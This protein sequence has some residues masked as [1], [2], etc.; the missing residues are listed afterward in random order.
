MS[1][2]E[3][4]SLIPIY[5]TDLEKNQVILSNVLLM[6]SRRIYID[7]KEDSQP[8]YAIDEKADAKIEVEADNTYVFKT[9][10]KKKYALR[11]SYHKLISIGKQSQIT[12][13]IDDYPDHVK[14]LVASDFKPAIAEY[15]TKHKV[16]LYKEDFFLEDI[17]AYIEQPKY[18]LLS[19]KQMEQVKA[20]YGVTNYTILKTTRSDAVVKYLGLKKGDIYKVVRPS[21]V[22]G[23]CFAYRI[24]M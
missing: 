8:L 24:V 10:N 21:P 17:L 20:E 5:K 18:V 19:P 14:I 2:L 13:F 23:F 11:I 1:D 4:K 6:L 3:K 22:A 15:A 9:L 16:Q 12:S 7:E